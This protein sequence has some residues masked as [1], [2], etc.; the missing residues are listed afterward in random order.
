MA[1]SGV[2]TGLQAFPSNLTRN[3]QIPSR[4]AQRWC[5][6]GWGAGKHRGPERGQARTFLFISAREENPEFMTDFGQNL[7]GLLS[8]LHAPRAAIT[9]C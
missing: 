7:K 5:H 4:A 9:G 1:I 3:N 6:R 8:A 2:V